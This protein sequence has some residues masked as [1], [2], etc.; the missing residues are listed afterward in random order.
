[1]PRG[2]PTCRSRAATV[3]SLVV[4]TCKP[5]TKTEHLGGRIAQ[6]MSTPRTG[7]AAL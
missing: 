2:G 1:M 6:K 5:R 7:S 4:Q 3:I